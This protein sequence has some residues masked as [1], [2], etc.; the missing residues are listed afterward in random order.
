MAEN[1]EQTLAHVNTYSKPSELRI[2]D[3]RFVEKKHTQ[4]GLTDTTTDCIWQ[5]LFLNH[6]MIWQ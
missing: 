2:T 4:S 6:L 1:Y 3:M 5:F